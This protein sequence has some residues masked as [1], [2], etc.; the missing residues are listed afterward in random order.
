M[1]DINKLPV[2]LRL[3]VLEQLVQALARGILQ[4]EYSKDLCRN[5]T[6]RVCQELAN[7]GDLQAALKAM[8]CDDDGAQAVLD[9]VTAHSKDF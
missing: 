6:E 3:E 7:K 4:H 1:T 8:A 9:R 5:N 2:E